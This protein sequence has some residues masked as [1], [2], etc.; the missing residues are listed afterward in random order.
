M[1]LLNYLFFLSFDLSV[2][3][4]T[5]IVWVPENIYHFWL[6]YAENRKHCIDIWNLLKSITAVAVVA[7]L[8]FV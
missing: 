8:L 6:D 4:H 3:Y 1:L 2:L 7:V 5:K